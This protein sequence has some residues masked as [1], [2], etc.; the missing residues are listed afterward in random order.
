MIIDTDTIFSLN[1]VNHNFSPIRRVV[2]SKGKAVIFKHNKAMYY[3]VSI[4]FLSKEEIAR[5]EQYH[6]EM[7]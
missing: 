7:N 2:D 5:L 6:K 3:V 1:E 4:D